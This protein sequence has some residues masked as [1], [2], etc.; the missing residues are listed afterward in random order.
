MFCWKYIYIQQNVWYS[1]WIS[2]ISF[3]AFIPF[4]L[5]LSVS[6]YYFKT[7]HKSWK[8]IKLGYKYGKSLKKIRNLKYLESQCEKNPHSVETAVKVPK[9]TQLD[10]ICLRFSVSYSLVI[11]LW[12]WF[13][14]EPVSPKSP[15]KKTQ[16]NKKY[17][18]RTTRYYNS[19]NKA[20]IR[21]L[22]WLSRLFFSSSGM[23]PVYEKLLT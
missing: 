19:T 9:C 14:S 16:K 17:Y 10:K 7:H 8:L 6:S 3:H 15:K 12:T 18:Q 1:F 22:K 11:S 2:Y 5:L 21:N 23:S 13:V 4:F 20:F